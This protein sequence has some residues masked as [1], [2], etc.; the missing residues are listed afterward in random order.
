[1]NIVHISEV[2]G[3]GGHQRFVLEI[4]EA[5]KVA[6][7]EVTIVLPPGVP[8]IAHGQA[9]PESSIEIL[10]WTS[11]DFAGADVIHSWGGLGEHAS[12]LKRRH[13][14]T[15]MVLTYLGTSAGAWFALA[16]WTRLGWYRVMV[17]KRQQMLRERFEGRL[18]DMVV[19]SSR[20]VMRELRDLYRLPEGKMSVIG[21]GCNLPPKVSSRAAARELLGLPKR[22]LLIGF[23][24]RP[25]PIKGFESVAACVRQL[26]HEMD[27]VRLVTAPA[28]SLPGQDWILGLEL[29]RHHIGDLYS[30]VDIL[31]SASRYEGY[32]LAIHEAMSIGLPVIVPDSAGIADRFVDGVN[33]L[34]LPRWR[35]FDARLLDSLRLL[36]TDEQLRLK[37]GDAARMWALKNTWHEVA[38]ELSDVYSEAARTIERARAL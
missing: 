15:P 4:A 12:A 13:P 8:I 7:E 23:V 14:A 30:A 6:G 38:A 11:T 10:D 22:G 19:P 17:V 21:G 3:V 1:V 37:L 31:V 16:R 36:A 26:R 27:D 24:G 34:I 20:K 5:Q 33:A 25:D 32:G 28:Q 29:D 2:R 35:G 18:A 9:L